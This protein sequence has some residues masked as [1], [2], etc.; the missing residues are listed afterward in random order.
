MAH[1]LGAEGTDP[2]APVILRVEELANVPTVANF[3][4]VQI[5]GGRYATTATRHPAEGNR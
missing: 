4:I 3:A 1:R 2:S 5:E